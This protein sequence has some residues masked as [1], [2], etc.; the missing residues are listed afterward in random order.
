M[1]D[2]LGAL[3]LPIFPIFTFY[4]P[5]LRDPL[6][7]EE[8]NLGCTREKHK[9]RSTLGK[10]RLTLCKQA[11]AYPGFFYRPFHRDPARIDCT[12]PHTFITFVVI[13]LPKIIFVQQSQ[14]QFNNSPKISPFCWRG[15]GGLKFFNLP[16]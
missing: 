13:L 15:G 2:P 12:S 3:R 9:L 16:S 8:A 1:S 5:Q 14:I 7:D 4:P 6:S 11:E 10:Q